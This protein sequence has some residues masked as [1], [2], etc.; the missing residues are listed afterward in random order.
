MKLSDIIITVIAGESLAV[1]A[2]QLLQGR[3]I[4]VFILAW[5][6][7]FLMPILAIVVFWLVDLISQK[8]LFI[9]QF[10][11]Y[12]LIG[13]IATLADMEIFI[14]LIWLV[15]SD[16]GLFHGAFKS[17]SFLVATY[18]KFLG[19]K[20]WT[21][22]EHEK[23]DTKKEFINFLL[24]TFLGLLLDVAGFLFFTKT[25]GP[26][27]GISVPVWREVSLILS[28]LVA[29]VWNFLG[30]KFIIFKKQV[31]NINTPPASSDQQLKP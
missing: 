23:K 11:K 5:L 1:I 19:N 18:V 9:Y 7:Y 29:A 15:D 27:F 21:F 6:F 8:Y 16:S 31:K 26:H 25:I 10:A 17:V 22:E 24:V 28:A 3:H 12:C 2:T 13:I 14:F 20:Y 30:Y 4:S